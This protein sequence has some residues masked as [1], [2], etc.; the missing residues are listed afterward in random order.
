MDRY[1]YKTDMISRNEIILRI[2]NIRD[3][4]VVTYRIFIDRMNDNLWSNKKNCFRIV[5]EINI[6]ILTQFL[7]IQFLT[8][9]S[10]LET[11]SMK[12]ISV[13]LTRNVC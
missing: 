12:R 9:F 2:A 7:Q 13:T 6:E 8:R 3:S 1:T 10:K 4:D 5:P 11:L